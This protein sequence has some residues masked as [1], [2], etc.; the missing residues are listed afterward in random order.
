VEEIG[1][2]YVVGCDGAHSTVRKQAGIAFE[3][4]A[5]LQDFMLGDVEADGSILP[6]ALNENAAEAASRC[7]SR[8]GRRQPGA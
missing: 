8:C 6:D 7:S 4:D 2:G 1:A 5:Y 3:G